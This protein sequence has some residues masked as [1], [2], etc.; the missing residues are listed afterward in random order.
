M[1]RLWD[2]RIYPVILDGQD[3]ISGLQD[4]RVSEL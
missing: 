2:Y 4:M 3:V 1:L